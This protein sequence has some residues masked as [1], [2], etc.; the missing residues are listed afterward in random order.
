MNGQQ[1]SLSI[2][3]FCNEKVKL[4]ITSSRQK[5]SADKKITKKHLKFTSVTSAVVQMKFLECLK[6]ILNEFKSLRKTFGIKNMTVSSY[7]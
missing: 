1:N 2:L 6:M 3:H 5:I 4:L 7:V